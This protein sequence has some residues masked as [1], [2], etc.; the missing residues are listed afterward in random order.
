MQISETAALSNY[1]LP[2]YQKKVFHPAVIILPGGAYRLNSTRE[3]SPIAHA[4]NAIGMQAFVL[5]YTTYE[6]NRNITLQTVLTEVRKTI[7]YIV[8]NA[9]T[10]RVNPE[11]IYII[12]FSAGGHLAAISGSLYYKYIKRVILAYPSLT[13]KYWPTETDS[14]FAGAEALGKII[15]V[16]AADYISKNT[17]PTFIWTTFNDELVSVYGIFDYVR[18]LK[19]TAIPTELHVYQHGPHGL[20][21]ANEA[22]AIDESQIDH[23]VATWFNLALSWLNKKN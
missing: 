11:E 7:E 23:H 1:L 18:R 4:F 17:P 2:V 6:K 16:D 15:G 10:L 20:S 21:L 3:G 8:E 9:E 19:Q 14:P 5:D 13:S 22:T 12:G